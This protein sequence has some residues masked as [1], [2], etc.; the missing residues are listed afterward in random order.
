MSDILKTQQSFARKAQTNQAHRFEDLYHLIC[1]Q[2]WISTALE[3]V[4]FNEGSRTAGVDGVSRNDL[5]TD[6]QKAA[7][8]T[9]LQADLK[10]GQYRPMPVRRQWIP[11]P[12]KTEKRGLGIP[13]I[14]D[15]VV[16]ELLRMLMEPIWE[17]DFLDCSHGFR[18]GRRTMDCI[19]VCY[20]RIHTQN[21]YFW[22]IEGD[23]RK[24]F[25]RINH[26]ILLKLVRQRI[27]DG[28]INALVEAIL[29]SGIMDEGLFQETKEG[30]PQGGILSP[31]LANIYL[32]QLDQW[33]WQK[34]GSLTKDEKWQ[35]RLAGLGNA[36][37]VR[38]ADDF[39]LLWN[40]THEAALALRDELKQ[41]LWDELHL[42]LS[43]EKTHVTHVTDGFNFLGFHVQWE[44][45]TDGH[46]PWLRVTPT[47]ENL[48]RF[49]AKIK[50]QTKRGT[51]FVTSEMKVKSLNRVIR[52]WGNYYR[53]VSF[54]H[55]ARELDFWINDR[56]LIWLKNK[57]LGK[58]VYW[59]LNEYKKREV[60]KRYN[61]WNFAML[62]SNGK[63]VFVTKLQD[64][65]LRAYRRKKPQHPYLVSEEVPALAEPDTP[66]LEPRVVNITPE[67]VAWEETRA[68]VRKRDEYRCQ[69]CGK[70]LTSLEVHHIK[71]R[72]HGGANDPENLET[73]CETCHAKTPTYG[74]PSRDEKSN[75]EPDDAKV[76]R[77]VRRRG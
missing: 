77:P 40:G 11:K 39:I 22:I 28:R 76:S 35:R 18:P 51:T 67:N 41:F 50:A 75:G 20:S 13:T 8:T 59:L 64:I 55:D 27:A 29:K 9:K 58:G 34:F 7:F 48:K 1:R 3:H 36:I 70:A 4:L 74:R 32:H 68:E 71:A 63:N 43:E 16:Q 46:K 73:L 19:Y 30:T 5:K 17:S 49:R 61:R 60:T 69:R 15:R 65:P 66:F 6:E 26:A 42:E 52:G 38:Y 14:R 53:H 2:D 23:I 10:T 56:V 54:S 31:L 12:G 33:W 25:D 62:D 37:L 45:P 21:K 47:E 24:C 57:H 72:R 44:L